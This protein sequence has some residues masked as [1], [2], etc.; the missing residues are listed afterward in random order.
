MKGKVLLPLDGSNASLSALIPAKSIAEILGMGLCIINISDE[1]LSKEELIVNLK[2]KD[3]DAGCFMIAQHQGVPDE[4]IIRE[5]RDSNYIVMG[6]HGYTCDETRRM[7]ST[8]AKVIEAANKPVLLIK[9]SVEM[10]TENNKWMPQKALIP[11][12]GAPGSAQALAPAINILA[13]T[14]ASID[15]LHIFEEKCKP[16]EEEGGFSAP[17]YEDYPQHEWPSWSKEFLKRFCPI[18][19]NHNH[20]KIN[21]S[22][23]TGDPA[24]EIISFAKTNKNDFIAIA[25]HGTM[26]RFRA[27]TLKS[28]LSEATCPIMLIKIKD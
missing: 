8:T 14:T 12:N 28:I 4:V 22:T 26:S 10:K 3:R 6:T 15:L 5:G 13:K 27:M 19:E 7:G 16:L 20:I 23:S 25:W 21:V 9:P 18:M 24:Q 2:L 11:L 1:E 17:Y